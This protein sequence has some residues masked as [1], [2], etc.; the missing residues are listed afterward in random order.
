MLQRYGLLVVVIEQA[1]HK[2]LRVLLV[3]V[4]EHV[5]QL[6]LRDLLVGPQVPEERPE[7][8]W[9]RDLLSSSL[10]LL[11]PC[12]LGL[13]EHKLYGHIFSRLPT[14]LR[15]LN[16]NTVQL[17]DEVAFPLGVVHLDQLCVGE[18]R[19]G[20]EIKDEL[21]ASETKIIQVFMPDVPQIIQKDFVMLFYILLKFV[22]ILQDSLPETWDG[23]R[24]NAV[25]LEDVALAGQPLRPPLQ[26]RGIPLGELPVQHQPLYPL[27]LLKEQV[28]VVQSPQLLDHWVVR[29]LI[30]E[31]CSTFRRSSPPS[32]TSFA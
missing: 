22:C 13:S 2:V 25:A 28:L 8:R 23:P 29:K 21:E 19:I 16:P 6:L 32:A 20:F 7:K 27:Q 24:R 30:L 1:I 14:N 17:I 11:L 18:E 9:T 10:A 5:L 12:T 4:V 3:L 31:F 26:D 15:C